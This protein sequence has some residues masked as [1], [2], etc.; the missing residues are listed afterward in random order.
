MAGSLRKTT[1]P[2]AKP[3]RGFWKWTQRYFRRASGEM[4]G[5]Q[6]CIRRAGE[7][8][9]SGERLRQLEKSFQLP[10]GWFFFIVSK[11]SFLTFVVFRPDESSQCL[12]ALQAIAFYVRELTNFIAFYVRTCSTFTPAYLAYERL[13]AF[14]LVIALPASCIRLYGEYGRLH[15]FL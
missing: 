7:V 1:P 10:A 12:H 14:A 6:G 4:N 5:G 15:L 13:P 11:N 9:A 3:F 2:Y 8:I